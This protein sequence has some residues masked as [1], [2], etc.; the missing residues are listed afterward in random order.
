LPQAYRIGGKA[1]EAGFE[2]HYG[3]I[4]ENL[5]RHEAGYGFG[6]ASSKLL[7]A[8]VLFEAVFF[9]FKHNSLSPSVSYNNLKASEAAAFLSLFSYNRTGPGRRTLI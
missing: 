3:G 8:S 4:V 1:F 6:E 5:L 9:E 7:T 2:A